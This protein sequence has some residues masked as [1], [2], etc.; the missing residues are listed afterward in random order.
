MTNLLTQQELAAIKQR[1]TNQGMV[2]G[3]RAIELIEALEARH[4]RALDAI[5]DLWK[6]S[7]LCAKCKFQ[8]I[9]YLSPVDECVECRNPQLDVASIKGQASD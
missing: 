7:R 1:W 8:P 6:K 3:L 9:N 2:D 5:E 4:T